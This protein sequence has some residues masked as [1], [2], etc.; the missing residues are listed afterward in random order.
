MK[1]IE[2]KD[3]FSES[4]LSKNDPKKIPFFH[5]GPENNWKTILEEDY[6]KKLTLI[7]QANLRELNYI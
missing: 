7:F 4:V 5:L 2:I 1:N 6:K 3:G